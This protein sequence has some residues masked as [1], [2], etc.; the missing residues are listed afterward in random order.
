MARR[1]GIDRALFAW[2]DVR[3]FVRRVI[4]GADESN[5]PF[6][7]SGLAFDA[8]LAAIP[9]LL[10]LLSVGGYI[11]S[12]KAGRAQVEVHEYIQRFLPSDTPE[13]S[14]FAPIVALIEKVVEGRGRLEL[15]GIPLFVW[16]ATRLFSSL[17]SALCEIF[18]VEETRPW[19][20]GKAVDCVLVI[21]TTLLFVAST[22]ISEG[23]SVLASTRIGFRFSEYF[24][25]QLLSFGAVLVLFIVI[26][27]VAP[28]HPVKWDTS[29]VAALVCAVGFEV[30]KQVL[31]VYFENM[32]RPDVIVRSATVAALLLLVAWT[33][34]VT[35]VF[36][37]GAQIAQVY[38][39]W[40]RQAAQ[41][42]LLH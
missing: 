32:A 30:A 24:G 31:S 28:A 1:G 6:L 16:F 15:F 2:H 13:K 29:L 25:A 19:L 3:N 41:R 34:Y 8:L 35:F 10:L 38:E 18:D 12:A 20:K 27:R 42:V 36:L 14:A 37:I 21:V 9:F 7:A 23:T 22:A 33:Y 5:V 40:R 39:L 26:F 4:E 17:R 11:L